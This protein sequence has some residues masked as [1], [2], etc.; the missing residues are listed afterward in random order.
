M[1]FFHVDEVTWSIGNTQI[2]NGSIRNNNGL[3]NIELLCRST[4]NNGDLGLRSDNP[5]INQYLAA[6][7][8]DEPFVLS[9]FTTVSV[10]V[11][12]N[13]N[14]L[15]KVNGTFTQSLSGEYTCYSRQSG[16]ESTVLLT[17]GK[18]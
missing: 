6:E 5:V 11:G 9:N 12:N 10:D 17:T 2:Y 7:L 4:K 18:F 1:F 16:V 3:D 14:I 8:F 13:N 15:L